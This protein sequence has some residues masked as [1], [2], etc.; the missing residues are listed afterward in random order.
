MTVT[1][2]GA[3]VVDSQGRNG[4][5]VNGLPLASRRRLEDR[6]EIGVC[7]QRVVFATALRRRSRSSAGIPAGQP[8]ND[9]TCLVCLTT[10]ADFPGAAHPA[11]KPGPARRGGRMQPGG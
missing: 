7:G 5:L 10:T 1:S 11:Q 6:D 2:D 3:F 8:Q 9:D 4:T